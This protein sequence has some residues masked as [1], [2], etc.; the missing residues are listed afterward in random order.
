MNL[1]AMM[2]PAFAAVLV[3]SGTALA[4]ET[5]R[6]VP[7]AVTG[8]TAA[9]VYAFIKTR[10][11]RVAKN[12]TFAFTMIATKTE[13]RVAGQGASCRFSRFKTSAFYAFYIP[14]H[15]KPATL[16]EAT[17]AK[18]Q[19]FE[20]YLKRHEEGHREIWRTCFAD[21]DAQ[22]LQLSAADCTL[23]DQA[24]EALFTGIK[25]ACLQQDEAYDARFR[26]EVVKH[27]FVKE[28]LRK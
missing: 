3:M 22:T 21:Y 6:T 26:K 27:P 10:A 9:D 14:R 2:T 18:W 25:K 19:A 8:R 5:S 24:R 1:I 11:P 23:L 4:G 13:K 16:P 15:A 28:A 20:D 7:Y 12:P 17:R